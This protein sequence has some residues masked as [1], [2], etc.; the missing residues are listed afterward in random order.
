[1]NDKSPITL[2]KADANLMMQIIDRAAERGLFNGQELFPVG[3]LRTRLQEAVAASED[4]VELF[5]KT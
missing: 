1:M 2:T 4:R 3:V 5:E